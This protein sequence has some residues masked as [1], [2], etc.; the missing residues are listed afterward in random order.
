LTLD[1]P[2]FHQ[3]RKKKRAEMIGLSALKFFLLKTDPVRDMVF[4]PDESIRFDGETGPYLQYTHARA[5]SLLEKARYHKKVCDFTMLNGA[6]EQTVI[7]LL[8]DFPARVGESTT[9]YSPHILCHYLLGLAQAFNEFYHSCPVI[10]DDKDMMQARLV[11]VDAV[12][13]VLHTGLD[14][15]GISAMKEM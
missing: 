11:L 10:S 2:A 9:Q 13:Q 7:K 1:T 5:C 6:P 15:L 8:A 14:L 4:N 3:K 12:R